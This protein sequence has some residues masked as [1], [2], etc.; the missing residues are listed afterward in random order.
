MKK[1]EV[2]RHCVLDLWPKVTKFNRV[3]ASARSNHLA[4]TASKSVHPFGWN[5]VHKKCRT[6]RHTHTHRHTDKLQWKYNPSTISW[7]CKNVTK[8]DT[9]LLIDTWLIHFSVYTCTSSLRLGI[10]GTNFCLSVCS[11][12]Q[13]DKPDA[14]Y[15]CLWS[16]RLCPRLGALPVPKW[17]PPG[18]HPNLCPE[19][20]F[21]AEDLKSL[22]H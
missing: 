6:H 20:E 15:H 5:F 22:A 3:R 16:F 8:V 21:L 1:K 11:G 4:K 10:L 18:I 14:P 7:R 19:G 17:P 2:S 13:V 9:N 12:S